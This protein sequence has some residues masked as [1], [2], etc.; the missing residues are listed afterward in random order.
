MWTAFY[1]AAIPT[2]NFLFSYVGVLPIFGTNYVWHPLSIIVGFWL[3]LR[4]FAHKELGDRWIFAPVFVGMALSYATSSPRIATASAIA[5]LVSE[6]IDYAVFR[7]SGRPLAQ[8]VLLSSAASV[9]VDSVLFSG[10]AFGLAAINPVTFAVMLCAKML[11]AA[12]VSMA[13]MRR[14]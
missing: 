11:G 1:I 13:L 4:D 10:I 12:M 14:A 3:V 5:F 6:C 9:P 2:T 8:R 7:W